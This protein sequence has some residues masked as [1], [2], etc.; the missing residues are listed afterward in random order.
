MKAK[1]VYVDNID[2]VTATEYYKVP[3]NTRAK[4]VFLHV[5]HNGGAG[6]HDIE[7]FVGNGTD[8]HIMH[9]K[10][11][12]VGQDVTL[13]VSQT[14]YIMLEPEDTIKALAGGSDCQLIV[15]VEETPFLVSTA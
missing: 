2:T 4:V 7:V 9:A 14:S 1:T 12:A 6:S 3:K 13:G 5:E 11:V 15:T 10:A 8:H